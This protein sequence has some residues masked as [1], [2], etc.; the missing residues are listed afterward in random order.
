M[1][2]PATL[3]ID[4]AGVVRWRVIEFDYRVRPSNADVMKA[5]AGVEAD[6]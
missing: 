4:R 3:V 1:A 2:H 5:V 6:R